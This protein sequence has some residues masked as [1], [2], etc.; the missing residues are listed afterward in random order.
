MTD[1]FTRFPAKEKREKGIG[2][3]RKG[4]ER[5]LKRKRKG[6]ISPKVNL[7]I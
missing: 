1:V 7:S 5:K 4:K 2:R 6:L 3:K